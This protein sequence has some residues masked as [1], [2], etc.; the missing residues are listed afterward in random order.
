MTITEKQYLKAKKIVAEYE[1]QQAHVTGLFKICF[2]DVEPRLGG[3]AVPKITAISDGQ[4]S[5]LEV[6]LREVGT[7]SYANF[8]EY[9]Y[10]SVSWLSKY[11]MTNQDIERVVEIIN[12]L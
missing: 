6:A 11:T 4:L 10:L 8:E 9:G 12:S 5:K 2:A 1:R 3:F 7:V